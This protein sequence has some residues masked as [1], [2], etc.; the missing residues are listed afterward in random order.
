MRLCWF[1]LGIEISFT[2]EPAVEGLVR[3]VTESNFVLWSLLGL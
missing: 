3:V 1:G 2:W